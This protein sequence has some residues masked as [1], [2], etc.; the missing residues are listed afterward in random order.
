MEVRIDSSWK[1]I[2]GAEFDKEY[3]VRLTEFVRAEYGRLDGL[4][5]R[6]EN[7]CS[8]RFMPV[9]QGQGGDPRSGSISWRRTS[10]RTVLLGQ[11][12]HSPPPLA[13]QYIQRG[14]CRHRHTPSTDGD[15]SRW[16]RQGV[17]MLNATLTVGAHSPG[18]HQ[19]HGW[20]EFTDAVV[21]NLAENA[22]GWCSS[23]GALTPYA[24]EPSS[25]A[26]DIWCSPRPHP[27]PL[28]AARGFFGN[29]HFTRTNQWLQ[30]HGLT[31]IA[32]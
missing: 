26:T 21:R 31:P 19:G 24:K 10:Q 29:H 8:I 1:E 27:S 3:F 30:S 13:R 17:L 5:A 28:S 22:R 4:S 2:L 18:S 20:E 9:R 7:L 23:S 6:L 16:A 32:W 25:I 12:G 15:L 11:S 14:G